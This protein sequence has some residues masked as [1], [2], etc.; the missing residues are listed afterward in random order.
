MSNAIPQQ[1]GQQLTIE[2]DEK[3]GEGT[4]SNLVL[5]SHSNAEFV[6]DFTRVL[7]GLPKAK[8]Q[9]RVILAPPHAKALLAALEENIKRY[10]EQFGK[11]QVGPPQSDRP[12][13]FKAGS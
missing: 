10:E 9:A 13:G 8:V 6:L 11:I 7:P 5:I 3:I 4:Y 12:F 1:Q 2:L